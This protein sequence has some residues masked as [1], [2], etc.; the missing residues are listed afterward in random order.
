MK[1]DQLNLQGQILQEES[2]I[3]DVDMHHVDVLY[4]D[5][6]FWLAE[7]NQNLSLWWS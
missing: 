3:M 7:S 1:A 4:V 2:V 6:H 5:M